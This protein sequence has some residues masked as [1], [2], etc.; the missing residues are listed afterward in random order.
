M[1]VLQSV[2]KSKDSVLV[3]FLHSESDDEADVSSRSTFP[4]GSWIGRKQ[5]YFCMYA[6]KT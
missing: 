2:L 4:P 6:A 5:S 3:P 1:A